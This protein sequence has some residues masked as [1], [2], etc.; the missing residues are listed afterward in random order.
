MKC[1]VVVFPGSNN[2]YDC[3]YVAKDVFGMDAEFVWHKETKLSKYDLIILPGGFSYGDYL[4]PGAIAHY[5]PIMNDVKSFAHSGGL[6]IG[7]CNGFQIL[8][9]TG[10]LPGSL[11]RNRDL[12]FI[13]DTV[14]LKVENNDTRFTSSYGLGQV[15]TLPVAHHDGNY[16]ATPDVVKGLEDNN[17]I[18]FRYAQKDGSITDS[19]N[20]NGS[21]GN[22][23]A[24]VNKEGNVFGTMPHPERASEI[25]L[26]SVEGRGVFESI[27]KAIA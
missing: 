6:V 3:L 18:V 22:I 21:V 14:D 8:C 26:G 11:S 17:Q 2:D 27:I 5:S 1:G 4:R 15:I 19:A 10:L 25:E 24:I 12:Q 20:P 9:E 16:F 13:C 23:A 7:I